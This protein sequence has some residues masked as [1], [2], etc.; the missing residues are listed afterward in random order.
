MNAKPLHLLAISG[1]LRAASA[2]TAV[3][4]AAIELAPSEV[5]ITLYDGL[6]ELPHFNPDL[7]GEIAPPAVVEFR[8][9]LAA[10]DGVLIS[11]PEYA[12]GVPGSFKNA[13]DWVVGS[14]EFVDKP[15][16]LINASPHSTW[17]LASLTET[18]TV[19]S[20]RL[21]DEAAVT[22]PLGSNRIDR[23]TILAD[24]GQ[25]DPLR[26]GLIRFSRWII[27]AKS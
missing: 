21:V 26:E 24:S 1:S 13:L 27:S 5:T 3:L 23:E 10:A 18:L 20:A 2:N 6:A 14:G 11:C 16:A 19:M 22:L 8:R 7:D 17:A 4:R 15:V 9:Q 12:H 25:A